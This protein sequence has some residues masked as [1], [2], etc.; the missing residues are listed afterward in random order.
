MSRWN[1]PRIGA[2]LFGLIALAFL[3]PLAFSRPAVAPKPAHNC[4]C[5]PNCQCGPDCQCNQSI[6]EF[7][8]VDDP[9]TDDPPPPKPKPKQAEQVPPVGAPVVRFGSGCQGGYGGPQ[10]GGC[11]GFS[12]GQWSGG[13][14]GFSA[15]QQTFAVQRASGGCEGG[16]GGSGILGRRHDRVQA[17]REA[18]QERRHPSSVQVEQVQFAPQP[19]SFSVPVQSVPPIAQ[20]SAQVSEQAIVGY[21][22]VCNGRDCF[23]QPVYQTVYR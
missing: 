11:Q 8:Y 18:R 1:L 6:Q 3:A 17:R 16:S 10:A 4:P 21:Q 12:A 13:C 22:Q 7:G 20:Q 15:G 2:T 23:W 14:Q 9:V 5:G 19:A